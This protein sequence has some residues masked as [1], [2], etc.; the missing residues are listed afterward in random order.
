VASGIGVM[1][2]AL[3]LWPA[4]AWAAGQI[5]GV[6]A[7][8]SSTYTNQPVT[9]TVSGTND[10]DGTCSQVVVR[11][12]A[13][14]A[15]EHVKTNATLPF[16]VTCMYSTTGTKTVTA[17]AELVNA[18]CPGDQIAQV[19][20]QTTLL[21]P[22]TGIKLP[23][24][25]PGPTVTLEAN[26]AAGAVKS[27]AATPECLR[28]TVGLPSAPH[29]VFLRV[30]DRQDWVQDP[31][32]QAG[33]QVKMVQ[34]LTPF[35]FCG[36]KPD[37]LHYFKVVVQPD[38]WNGGSWAYPKGK[39]QTYSSVWTQRRDLEVRFTRVD[40]ID[41][42]DDLS[43]GDMWFRVDLNKIQPGFCWGCPQGVE[44]GSGET[45]H[46]NLQNVVKNVGTS[47]HWEVKGVDNDDTGGDTDDVATWEGTLETTGVRTWVME[48]NNNGVHF[49]AYFETKE[50]L[51]QRKDLPNLSSWQ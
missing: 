51:T 33:D 50:I 2:A 48:R 29:P 32:P 27:I 37:T 26:L 9:V 21:K 46:P 20:V 14:A 40:L 4:G 13:P 30:S 34:G 28:F 44:F 19:T 38:G 25:D 15:P 41:D 7:N 36:R 18:D 16:S 17:S 42:S 43:D 1:L 35:E 23:G 49:K 6:V 22:G 12:Q 24:V 47:A 5:T 8:P 10:R 39:H 3:F 11:C 45:K 31:S